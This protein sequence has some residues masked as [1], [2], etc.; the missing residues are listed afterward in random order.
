MKAIYLNIIGYSIDDYK[1]HTVMDPY[2]I[3][4]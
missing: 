4:M 3:L 1:C 2:Y